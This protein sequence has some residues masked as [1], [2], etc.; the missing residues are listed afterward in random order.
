MEITARLIRVER[1]VTTSSLSYDTEGAAFGVP[2][3]R[4]S[5]PPLINAGGSG[6][7]MPLRRASVE[8]SLIHLRCTACFWW[9][10]LT[11][12]MSRKPSPSLCLAY[13]ATFALDRA[14]QI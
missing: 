1:G 12:P 11:V 7:S 5:P 9:L 2:D 8:P 13:A 14:A 3:V 6:A 4:L 10:R